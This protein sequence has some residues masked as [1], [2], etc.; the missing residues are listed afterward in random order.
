MYMKKLI[1]LRSFNILYLVPST[2]NITH[3]WPFKNDFID[4]I[5]G[6]NLT[7][8]TPT[9]SNDRFNKAFEAAR[10]SNNSNFLTAPTGIYFYS[11]N[12]TA[13]AW[14]K[15]YSCSEHGRI[16]DF[17]DGPNTNNV[18]F[19]YSFSSSC[20][21]HANIHDGVS[22]GAQSSLSLS[23]NQWYHVGATFSVNSIRL[24]I[25]G[26]LDGSGSAS[27]P[28]IVKNRTSCFIG[29]GNYGDPGKILFYSNL[30]N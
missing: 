6:A 26:N 29:K 18:I 11:Q 20:K 23:P 30:L 17:A 28:I 22:Q 16:F 5:G 13:T 25:N 2:L 9:M 3:Y 14:I 8:S 4:V 19:L 27:T 12:L 10:T 7:V 21:L 1:F 24:Y 15:I